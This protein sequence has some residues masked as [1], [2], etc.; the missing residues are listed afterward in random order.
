MMNDA[1][2]GNA[3]TKKSGG[4]GFDKLVIGIVILCVAAGVIYQVFFCST[5]YGITERFR[6][7]T[8]KTDL[9]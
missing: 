9:K 6:P 1:N 4:I 7:A 2:E 5:C 8:E 3:P